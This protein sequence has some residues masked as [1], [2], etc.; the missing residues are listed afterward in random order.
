MGTCN[1]WHYGIM[2]IPPHPETLNN[3]LLSLLLV[4]SIW[5][6]VEGNHIQELVSLAKLS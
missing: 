6:F 4:T 3:C 1:I 2:V 5:V